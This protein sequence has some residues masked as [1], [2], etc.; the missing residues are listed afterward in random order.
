MGVEE[1]GSGS[2]SMTDFNTAVLKLRFLSPRVGYFLTTDKN[3]QVCSCG[4]SHGTIPVC[5][6]TACG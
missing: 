6:R 1:T 4:V 3:V 5:N 2:C